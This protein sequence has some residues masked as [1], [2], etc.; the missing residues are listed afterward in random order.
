MWGVDCVYEE[1]FR[2]EMREAYMMRWVKYMRGA[3]VLMK[4]VRFVHTSRGGDG[5]GGIHRKLL[6]VCFNLEI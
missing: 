6:G 2:V 1:L 3:A 4:G 5:G